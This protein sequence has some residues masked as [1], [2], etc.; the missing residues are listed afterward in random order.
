[1]GKT[2]ASLGIQHARYEKTDGKSLTVVEYSFDEAELNRAAVNIEKA[3]ELPAPTDEQQPQAGKTH[4]EVMLFLEQAN[5][6]PG[7]QSGRTGDKGIIPDISEKALPV[8]FRKSIQELKEQMVRS[9]TNPLEMTFVVDVH[10][11]VMNGEVKG[12]TV[13]EIHNSFPR[14]D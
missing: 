9:E 11:T 7:K 6:A 1:L 5:R 12:Y 4:R 8:Y 13:L 2:G 14:E 10:T 3:L